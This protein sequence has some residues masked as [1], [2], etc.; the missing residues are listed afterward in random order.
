MYCKKCGTEIAENAKFCES[1]GTPVE[2]VPVQLEKTPEVTQT[3]Q[4]AENTPKKKK[5]KT[6]IILLTPLVVFLILALLLLAPESDTLSEENLGFTLEEFVDRYNSTVDEHLYQDSTYIEYV[7]T[8]EML[9]LDVD[10][11]YQ[12]ED[13]E[14]FYCASNGFMTFYVLLEDSGEKV[15]AILFRF[16]NNLT[17]EQLSLLLTF[18]KWVAEAVKPNMGKDYYHDTLNNTIRNGETREKGIA[19]IWEETDDSYSFEL[20]YAS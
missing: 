10:V 13:H 7:E 2:A 5:R 3:E 8:K 9:K 19:Y 11:F 16:P 4:K 15:E 17:E 14:D 6:W 20:Y 12:D 1:C 18:C